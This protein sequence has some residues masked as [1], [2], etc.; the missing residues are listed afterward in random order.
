MH[1]EAKVKGDSL[2]EFTVD[3]LYLYFKNNK[4]QVAKFT[5]L[6]SYVEKLKQ[7]GIMFDKWN[8]D[9]TQVF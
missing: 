7:L 2:L 4:K 8:G 1:S 3:P 6:Y 5:K 9:L